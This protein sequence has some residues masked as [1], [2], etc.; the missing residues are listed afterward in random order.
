MQKERR[1]QWLQG[2]LSR[3]GQEGA[4]LPPQLQGSRIPGH[5]KSSEFPE[6]WK[7]T[8]TTKKTQVRTCL[9]GH[10]T[11]FLVARC[12]PCE[13]NLIKNPFPYL[14]KQLQTGRGNILSPTY[15]VSGRHL[16]C[17]ALNSKAVAFCPCSVKSQT[18]V[19]GWGVQ[20]LKFF[21]TLGIFNHW[22]A[23]QTNIEQNWFIW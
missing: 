1:N 22:V 9:F 6:K 20:W 11:S 10:E 23:V 8:T 4:A 5:P 3:A 13:N 7:R 15:L 19:T 17:S 12:A 16:H 2:E 18:V 14:W 21:K